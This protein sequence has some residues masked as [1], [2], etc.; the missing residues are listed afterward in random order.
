MAARRFGSVRPPR[1][2]CLDLDDTLLDSGPQQEAIVRTCRE[3]A[4]VHAELDGARL[5]EANGKVW[6]SYWPEIGDR[7]TLGALDSASVSLEA[8]RRTLRTCGCTDEAAVHLATQTHARLERE[9]Y[10]LFDDVHEFVTAARGAE[11]PLA[12]ITNG[13]PDMQRSKLDALGIGALVQDSRDLRG[14]G[15]RKARPSDLR[16]RPPRAGCGDAEG[17]WHV[18]DN[19][20]TDVAGAQA[21][22][23]TGVWINRTGALHA[24]GDPEPDVEI[25]SLS[26]LIPLLAAAGGRTG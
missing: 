16:A 24:E 3:V 18:G 25:R 19:L 14:A 20:A 23:L 11:L 13:H 1:A 22:G 6:E 4:A 7:W 26:E 15:P 8:W 2:L 17:V 12:L 21:A 9:A 10:R 5:V